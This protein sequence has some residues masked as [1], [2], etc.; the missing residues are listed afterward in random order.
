VLACCAAPCSGFSVARATP[1]RSLRCAGPKLVSE[2]EWRRQQQERPGEEPTSEKPPEKRERRQAASSDVD[3]LEF[4]GAVGGGKLTREGIKQ[5]LRASRAIPVVEAETSLMAACK[6]TGEQPP[7]IAAKM[8]RVQMEE[9]VAVGVSV[10]SPAMKRAAQLLQVLE[11]AAETEQKVDQAMVD[12]LADKM[13][14]I[15]DEGYVIPEL[16][17]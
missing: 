2:L 6:E 1:G 15:F 17:L 3:D 16:D 14:A 13:S 9:A 5:S 10:S 7:I 4:F 11:S 8:L 12:P